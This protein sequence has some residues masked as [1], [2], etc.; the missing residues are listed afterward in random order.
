[1]GCGPSC[2]HLFFESPADATEVA[3]TSLHSGAPVA[4]A[5]HMQ[6]LL[7]SCSTL[8]VRVSGGV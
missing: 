3:V 5:G 1:M 8:G 6:S 2:R 4:W 7:S